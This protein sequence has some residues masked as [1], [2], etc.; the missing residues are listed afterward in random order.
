M[1]V[2]GIGSYVIEAKG[3]RVVELDL[4][5]W[6]ILGGWIPGKYQVVIRVDNLQVDD[7]STLEVL[8]EPFEFTIGEAVGAVNE[9]KK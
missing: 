1:R 7:Y 2:A 5:K 4:S 8:S 3:S 9:L 6:K